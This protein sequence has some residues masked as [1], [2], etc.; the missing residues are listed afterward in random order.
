MNST[1]EKSTIQKEIPCTKPVS[2]A[3]RAEG[4]EGTWLEQMDKEELAWKQVSSSDL[5][6]EIWPS[7]AVPNLLHV[8]LKEPARLVF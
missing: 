5:A 1:L 6:L 8:P 4:T 2:D 7:Q 3:N